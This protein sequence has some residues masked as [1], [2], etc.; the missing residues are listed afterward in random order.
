MTALEPFRTI[1]EGI[2]MRLLLSVAICLLLASCASS[3][4]RKFYKEYVDVDSLTDIQTLAKGEEPTVVP[5]TNL[6]RDVKAAIAKGYVPIGG[7]SFNGPVDSESAIA[8]QARRYGAVYV[9]VSSRYTDTTSITTPLLLP[10]V[11]RTYGSGTISSGRSTAT[12]SGTTTTYG[13]IAVPITSNERRYDQTTVYF[14]K[15]TRPV[16]FGIVP[17]D[18]S[19]EVRTQLER[20]SGAIVDIVTEGSPAF[21]ANVIPGDVLIELDGVAVKNG[22]HARELMQT[23]PSSSTKSVIKVIRKGSQRLI[24]LQLGEGQ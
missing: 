7:S 23:T 18:L 16:R 6:H 10:D 24:E 14:V 20:N 3:G 21:V 2:P 4:Q 22:Q 12:Y 1:R 8:K 9:L 13:T 11:Q 19:I 5:T 15:S 17:V